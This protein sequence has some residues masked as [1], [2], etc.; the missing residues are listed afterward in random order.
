MNG[1]VSIWRAK[2]LKSLEAVWI[3]ALDSTFESMTKLEG[4]DWHQIEGSDRFLRQL[5]EGKWCA[6]WQFTDSYP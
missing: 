4:L 1:L 2:Y 6:Y 5:W 3:C